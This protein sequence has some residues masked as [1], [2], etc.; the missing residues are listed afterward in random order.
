MKVHN[1]FFVKEYFDLD[2][3]SYTKDLITDLVLGT[4]KR[5]RNKLPWK[6]VINFFTFFFLLFSFISKGIQEFNY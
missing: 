1:N 2:N 6:L 4:E 3:N 5:V